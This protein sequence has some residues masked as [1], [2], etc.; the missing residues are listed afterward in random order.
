MLTRLLCIVSLAS[1]GNSNGDAFDRQW[2]VLTTPAFEYLTDEPIDKAR[3]TVDDLS[4]FRELFMQLLPEAQG[5]SGL[6]LKMV[7]F[8]RSND[9]H[10]ATGSRHF[11]GYTLP[12]LFE[13]RLLMTKRPSFA[14]AKVAFHEYAHYLLRNQTDRSYPLWYEEGLATYLSAVKFDAD[15]MTLGTLPGRRLSQTTRTAVKPS[16]E[17]VVTAVDIYRWPPRHI[18]VFYDKAWLMVH[19][20]RLGDQVGFDDLH[21]QLESY[22]AD[23]ARGFVE[24]FAIT[25]KSMNQLLDRYR[26]QNRLGAETVAYG[27]VEPPIPTTRCLTDQERDFEMAVSLTTHNPKLSRELLTNLDGD[28]TADRLVAL[29]DTMPADESDQALRL[30]R[31]ALVIDPNHAGA[32]IGLAN[33]LVGRCSFINDETCFDLWLEAAKYY[34]RA[35]HINP[36]RFDA[37][38]GLGVAYTHVGRAGDGMNYLQVAYNK[39]PW[40]PS[41]NFY[42]GEGYRII[43]DKRA[44]TYLSNA[45]N[46]ATEDFWRKRAELALERVP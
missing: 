34:R 36:T 14:V 9:F 23:P 19:F 2:C 32:L 13:Y 31:E 42:L 8:S 38:F 11:G 5:D 40:A 33:N 1:T 24:A 21:V 4:R 45:R 35:L 39:A 15:A 20:L 3:V 27:K 10:K 6:P 37:A 7:M 44:K 25:P 16:L 18:N 12:S 41:I 29:S 26:K 28:A 22:L 46:W 43:G 30:I 17:K